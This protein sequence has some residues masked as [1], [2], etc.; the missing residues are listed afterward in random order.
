MCEH[1]GRHQIRQQVVHS[2][3][4]YYMWWEERSGPSAGGGRGRVRE[5][6]LTHHGRSRRPQTATQIGLRK[7]LNSQNVVLAN[8]EKE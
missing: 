7:V 4:K 1:L 3:Y 6:E 2:A 8:S 5:G